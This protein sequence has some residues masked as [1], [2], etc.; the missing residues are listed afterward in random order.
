MTV[1]AGAIPASHWTQDRVIGGG[2]IIG[3]ACHFIDLAR[4]LAGAAI[5]GF[6]AK[7]LKTAGGPLDSAVLTLTFAN[8]AVASIQYLA[9]GHR[10]MPKEQVQVF[11]G[12]KSWRLDNFRRLEGYGAPGVKGRLLG[13][14][15][16]GQDAMA[17]LVVAALSEGKPAPIPAEELFEVARV[18]I[19]LDRQLRNC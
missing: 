11:C 3:E 12:G 15:D 9:N 4:F 8:G 18:T 5:T 17:R 14:Q 16:K 13:G 10:S 2:R 7:G 19:A 1:N 6:D